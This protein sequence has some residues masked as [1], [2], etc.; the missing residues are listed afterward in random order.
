MAAWLCLVN[1]LTVLILNGMARQTEQ[2]I[3]T[4][5][6]EE[7]IN[8]VSWLAFACGARTLYQD[9]QIKF[10]MDAPAPLSTAVVK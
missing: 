9:A 2:S 5:W 10:V 7:M 4:Q 3:R 8:V 6:I 1:L